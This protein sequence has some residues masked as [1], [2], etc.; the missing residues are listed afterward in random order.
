MMR[1]RG[2]RVNLDRRYVGAAIG[3]E[4]EV[5]RQARRDRV[6]N[7]ARNTLFHGQRIGDPAIG[8]DDW[9]EPSAPQ[10]RDALRLVSTEEADRP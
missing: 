1:A 6:G 9:V 7:E 5:R 2:A 3:Q 4:L 10:K 8:S